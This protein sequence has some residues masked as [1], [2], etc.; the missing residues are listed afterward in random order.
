[1]GDTRSYDYTLIIATVLILLI[2]GAISLYSIGYYHLASR[3]DPQWAEGPGHG[4]YLDMMNR[5]VFPAV[6]ML[7]IVIGLCIPKRVVPRKAI[8]QVSIIILGI[9]ILL[10]AIH[11]MSW[12][13]GFLLIVTI[14]VQS[15]SL[16]LTLLKR[17]RLVYEKE[18]YLVQLGSA[19]L[20]LGV[21]ILIFDIAILK[22]HTLHIPIFWISTALVLIGMCLSFYGKGLLK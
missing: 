16:I 13:L 6:A 20:H 2:I 9:T 22:G 7:L 4:L 10:Y 5:L 11:G 3:G 17:G 15:W 12:G 18:G 8:K 19:L 21:I 14:G 1:M